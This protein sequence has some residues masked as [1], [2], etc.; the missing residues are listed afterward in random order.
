MHI[1][2]TNGLGGPNAADG[3]QLLPRPGSKAGGV[4]KAADDDADVQTPAGVDFTQMAKTAP[5][6]NTDAVAE[7]RRLMDSGE[8]SS[9]EAI[10]RAAESMIQRGI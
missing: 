10:R 7:A 5:D 9:P 1:E 4:R 6:V 8:L 3:G 2:R